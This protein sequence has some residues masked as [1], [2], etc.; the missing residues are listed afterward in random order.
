MLCERNNLAAIVKDNPKTNYLAFELAVG[1]KQ[2]FANKEQLECLCTGV[3][4]ST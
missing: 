1:T 3:L 4:Q 2:N